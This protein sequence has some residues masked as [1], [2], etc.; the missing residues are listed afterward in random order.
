M[1]SHAGSGTEKSWGGEAGAH[2][3][4]EAKYLSLIAATDGLW[5]QLYLRIFSF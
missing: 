1:E 2:A 5:L 3:I 4:V